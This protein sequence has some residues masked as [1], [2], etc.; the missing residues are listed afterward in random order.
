MAALTVEPWAVW[1]DLLAALMVDWKAVSS[2]ALM[3]AMTAGVW[4]V[5]KVV[6]KVASSAAMTV[7]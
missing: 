5:T 7:E 6:A 2:V 4:A 3:V 1:V